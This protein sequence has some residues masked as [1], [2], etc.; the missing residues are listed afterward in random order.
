M[1]ISKILSLFII[2]N[3]ISWGYSQTTESTPEE[4][5]AILTEKMTTKLGLN[6]DQQSK[7]A[8]MNL[9]IAMKNDAV[10]KNEAMTAEQKQ[11]AIQGNND[12]RRG[13][14]KLILTEDQY[15]QFVEMENN[16]MEMKKA[17]KKQKLEKEIKKLED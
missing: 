7:V 14:F 2:V 11:A 4:K 12:A 13:Y 8:E 10:K 9:G 16:V 17:K 6:A 5:A 15:N 1:N 3:C